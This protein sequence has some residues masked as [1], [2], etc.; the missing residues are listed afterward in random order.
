MKL[1][2]FHVT[3]LYRKYTIVVAANNLVNLCSSYWSSRACLR[4]LYMINFIDFWQVICLCLFFFIGMISESHLNGSLF[5]YLSDIDIIAIIIQF[6]LEHTRKHVNIWCGTSLSLK[7]NSIC[8][9]ILWTMW[10]AANDRKPLTFDIWF[11]YFLSNYFEN[12]L[13]ACSEKLACTCY[14]LLVSQ[15][16]DWIELNVCD[17]F[18]SS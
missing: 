15:D 9:H 6:F 1:Q 18:G 14:H 11:A 3:V 8:H 10:V 17:R 13:S 2:A 16:S 4:N 12:I 7:H 5:A